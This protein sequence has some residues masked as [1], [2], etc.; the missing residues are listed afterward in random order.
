LLT[1]DLLD[2]IDQR[3]VAEI[4][5]DSHCH[6]SLGE[7]ALRNGS[8]W[9]Q[10]AYIVGTSRPSELKFR[11][12]ESKYPQVVSGLVQLDD[13]MYV[14]WAKSLG[15]ECNPGVSGLKRIRKLATKYIDDLASSVFDNKDQFRGETD[16]NRRFEI[17]D[18]VD[19]L[20]TEYFVNL[21]IHWNG[22]FSEYP[23]LLNDIHNTIEMSSLPEVVKQITRADVQH[24]EFVASGDSNPDSDDSDDSDLDPFEILL[25]ESDSDGW[26]EFGDGPYRFNDIEEMAFP[27]LRGAIAAWCKSSGL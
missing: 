24:I 11:Y 25:S 13:E 1:D 6:D 21:F 15:F 17:V 26:V 18:A 2:D 14:H 12:I 9:L 19:K 8:D 3:F 7:W 10:A 20:E 4:L 16:S 22:E 23:R 27:R 5:S